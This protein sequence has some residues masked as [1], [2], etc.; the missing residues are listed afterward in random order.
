LSAEITEETWKPVNSAPGLE[1]SSLGRIRI[2]PRRMAMPR[3]GFKTVGGTAR[4][5]Q[6]DKKRARHVFRWNGKTYMVARLVCEAFNGPAPVGAL[7]L[8]EDE[9][10]ANNRPTNLVWGTQ[11]QNLNYPGFL[12]YCRQRTGE[13]SAFTKGK[14]A[15]KARGETT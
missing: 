13:N 11:K 10:A 5:G 2:V 14:R 4:F 9:D 6:F 15:R 12:A 1:A 8:H 3:G 7:C